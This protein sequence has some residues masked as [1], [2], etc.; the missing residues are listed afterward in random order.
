MANPEDRSFLGR[1]DRQD[2]APCPE[3]CVSSRSPSNSVASNFEAFAR[4]EVASWCRG[5]DPLT[6]VPALR[7]CDRGSRQEHRHGTEDCPAPADDRAGPPL[8]QNVFDAAEEPATARHCRQGQRRAA[9]RDKAQQCLGVFRW[10]AD[11]SPAPNR[12]RQ[13]RRA[14][15]GDV[16]PTRPVDARAGHRRATRQ[17]GPTNDRGEPSVPARAKHTNPV[18]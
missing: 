6:D 9:L 3:L 18:D 16:S 7:Q 14:V 1:F 10:Q 5:V 15:P 13:A 8:I 12:R 17:A 11:R 4:F 2:R